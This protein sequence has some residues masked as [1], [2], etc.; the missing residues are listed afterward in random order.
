VRCNPRNL[1]GFAA[2]WHTMVARPA[3]LPGAGSIARAWA[4]ALFREPR[5]DLFIDFAPQSTDV[6]PG[7]GDRR[8]IISDS[9]TLP[10]SICPDK[11]NEPFA[12]Q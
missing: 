8:E 5:G 9:R 12:V 11:E 3:G 1:R 10:G 6:F 2:R 7:S 4:S